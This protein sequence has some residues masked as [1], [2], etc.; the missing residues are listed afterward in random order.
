MTDRPTLTDEQQGVFDAVMDFIRAG[1]VDGRRWFAY[2]GLAGCGKSILLAELAHALPRATPC[3]LFGKAAYNLAR[4]SGLNVGTIH[5]VIY[6]LRGEDVD[7]RGRRELLFDRTIT[8]GA[9]SRRVLLCDESGVIPREVGDDLLRTGALVVAAGDPGQLPPVKG[10]RFFGR[11]DAALT[12]VHRQAWDS[13]IIRQAHAVRHEGRFA[14]DGDG[15][16]V[17]DFIDAAGIVETDVIL[18]WRNATRRSLN[19][20][21]RAHLGRPAGRLL[22]GEPLMCLLNQHDIGLLNGMVCALAEDYEAG[23]PLAVEV[24]GDPPRRMDLRRAWVEDIDPDG[25]NPLAAGRGYRDEEPV[26]P[27][28]VAYSATCHKYIGSETDDVTVVAEYDRREW[29]REWHYSAITR[30]VKRCTVLRR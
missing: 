6:A 11:A 5:S 12:E 21:K 4:K 24:P 15:F 19:A 29:W 27:F 16:R 20:L 2:E 9:L 8:D 13:P 7:E 3:C 1:G 23:G 28:A 18:C 26:V 25:A 14:P 17:V 30:A 22:A 10:E